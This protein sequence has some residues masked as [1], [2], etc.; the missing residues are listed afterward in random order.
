MKKST[1]A[2]RKTIRPRGAKKA[3]V[4]KVGL[5]FAV[6]GKPYFDGIPWTENPSVS[7]FRIYA[8]EHPDYWKRL[9]EHRAAPIDMHHEDA[10]RG[11]A[12]CMDAT[13][14]F[15]LLADRCIIESKPLLGRIMAALG[16]PKGTTVMR[17]PH[18]RCEVCMG[19][20][21]TKRQEREDWDF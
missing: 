18:Y 20:V 3:K 4:P 11:R 10:A 16:L 6:N 8:V 13:G 1:A 7:G 14:G 2:G 12:N 19:K 17:G 15:T 9:Q 5:F 21:P